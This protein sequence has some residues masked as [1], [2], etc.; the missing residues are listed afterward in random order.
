MAC[1]GELCNLEQEIM[2][3]TI[4]AYVASSAL[5]ERLTASGFSVKFYGEY[6]MWA[7]EIAP[8]IFALIHE[9]ESGLWV[10]MTSW[11]LEESRIWHKCK[12][13]TL[14]QCLRWTAWA[15][16]KFKPKI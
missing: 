7:K 3:A 12:P 11:E 8:K 6:L 4:Q 1:L 5:T 10:S 13:P 2:N 16:R 14:D 9:T 15:E